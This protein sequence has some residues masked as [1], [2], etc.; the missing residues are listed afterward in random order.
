MMKY[1]IMKRKLLFFHHL[2]NLPSNSLANEVFEVQKALNLP[3]LVKECVQILNDSQISDIKRFSKPQWKNL[4]VKLCKKKNEDDLLDQIKNYKKLDFNEL[5]KEHCNIKH[6]MT[7]LNLHS[8][9]LR[10]KIR[11]KMTPTIQM[12]FKSDPAF[13]AN[14]WICVGCDNETDDGK[15]GSL[16]TQAHVLVCEAYSDLR[17]GKTLTNDKD[18]VDYFAGVIRRRLSTIA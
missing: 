7:S 11:A 5:K 3:G 13:K 17:D 18:L 4:I 16:D 12:N 9:R 1:R 14:M 8:A 15:I 10:F 2:E 6:Y